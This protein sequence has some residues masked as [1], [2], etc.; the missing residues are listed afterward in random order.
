MK[1]TTVFVRAYK[2][3][4]AGSKF[5]KWF[6]FGQYSHVSF[7]FE[8]ADGTRLERESIQG[9]GVIT[10]E[11]TSGKEFDLFLVPLSSG[12]VETAW[13]I[14]SSINGKYDWGG[15]WGFVRRKNK[16]SDVKWFCSE[17]VAYVLYKAGYRLSRRE[18]YRETP[19]TVAE[20]LRLINNME[21]G[22][23]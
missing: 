6:T 2:G 4:G 5:I 11:P 7:E 20:S 10:H 14:A 22:C 12:Q 9:A 8:F 15:I 23:A 17:F 1:P 13:L 16:H 18:P 21:T 19:S 3:H